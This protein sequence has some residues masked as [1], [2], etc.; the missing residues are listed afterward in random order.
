M[1]RG[2]KVVTYFE[3]FRNPEC[4]CLQGRSMQILDSDAACLKESQGFS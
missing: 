3:E 4:T 1:Y 2:I